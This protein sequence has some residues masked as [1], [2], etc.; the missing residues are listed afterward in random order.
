M[1]NELAVRTI[2]LYKKVLSPILSKWVA[3]RFYPTCSEYAISSIKTYGLAQGLK[4][5]LLRL[6][7]CN[8]YNLDSCIDYP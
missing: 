1:L 4:K 6:G 8:K 3:C 2:R 7:R 5:T